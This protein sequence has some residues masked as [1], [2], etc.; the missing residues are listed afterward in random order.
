MPPRK[1]DAEWPSPRSWEHALSQ[2]VGRRVARARGSLP[3]SRLVERCDE[4]G[5]P[6]GRMVI[7]NLE[8][9]RRESVS[10]AEVYVLAA[11]LDVAP[12]M[13]LTGIGYD[14]DFRVLPEVTV[15]TFEAHRWL[16]TGQRWGSAEPDDSRSAAD[17]SEVIAAA[18]AAEEYAASLGEAPMVEDDERAEF[19]ARLRKERD[20]VVARRKLVAARG[21]TPPSPPV[22]LP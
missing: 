5:M 4:L 20:R 15:S 1:P 17:L 9:G 22:R 3:I 12:T 18:L 16:T 14:V 8:A 21:L 19:D 13:L 2:Q 7:A 10:I 11:A 6:L